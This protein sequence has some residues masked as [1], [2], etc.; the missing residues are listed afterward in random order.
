M[1]NQED[2]GTVPK[3]GVE[4]QKRA[5][6]ALFFAFVIACV[7]GSLISFC[8]IAFLR[9]YMDL[10]WVTALLLPLLFG[11]AFFTDGGQVLLIEPIEN[12]IRVRL[13]GLESTSRTESRRQREAEYQ[14]THGH[15]TGLRRRLIAMGVR[16][17]GDPPARSKDQGE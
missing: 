7:L 8:V 10:P 12:L 2:K 15:P 13:M 11:G 14:R 16:K 6:A 1:H 17:E 4:W 5:S 3:D 9:L